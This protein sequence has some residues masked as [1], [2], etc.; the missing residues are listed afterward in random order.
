MGRKKGTEKIE[1]KVLAHVCPFILR[2]GMGYGPLGRSVGLPPWVAT[3]PPSTSVLC[4]LQ[5]CMQPSTRSR[6]GSRALV[7][8]LSLVSVESNT[9]IGILRIL[10][11]P[12][13]V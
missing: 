8:A 1:M 3:S 2:D 10:P 9:T 6:A 13:Q 12:T 4:P 5:D 7:R 11:V